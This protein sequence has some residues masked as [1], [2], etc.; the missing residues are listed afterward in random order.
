MRKLLFVS[1]GILSFAAISKAQGDFVTGILTTTAASCTLGAN[2]NHVA[3][4]SVGF[5]G[6]V[7]TLSAGGFTGAVTFYATG[8]GGTVWTPLAVTPSGGGTAV[9]TA[10]ATGAWQANVSA[11]THVCILLTTDTAGSI[12]AKI[13]LSPISARAGGGGGG[14]GMIYPGAGIAVSTGSAWGTSITGDPNAIAWLTTPTAVNLGTAL[15]SQPANTVFAAPSGAAGNPTFRPLVAADLPATTTSLSSITSA[16]TIPAALASGANDI[17]WNWTNTTGGSSFTFGETNPSTGGTIT[18]AVN[19][20]AILQALT[21]AGSTATPLSVTQGALTGT[22]APPAMQLSTTWNASGT[23][24]NGI[25]LS[26]TNTA[27]A[28]GSEAFNIMNNG[29]SVFSVTPGGL[30]TANIFVST[31]NGGFKTSAGTVPSFVSTS[32]TG[33]VIIAGGVGGSSTNGTQLGSVVL[34]GADNIANGA[35]SSGGAALLQGGFTQNVAGTGN[36]GTVE[37][38]AGFINGTVAN[39]NDIVCATTGQSTV[40]DCGTAPQVNVIGV[41]LGSSN[42]VGVVVQGL[43]PVRLSAPLTAI[44]DTV[45]L[46]TTTAGTGTDSGGQGMCAT[47]GATVGVIVNSTG[48][49]QV[50]SSGYAGN[51]AP[52]T[53]TLSTTLPL[54]LLHIR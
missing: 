30:T 54:V 7:F 39:A 12:A 32:T 6:A 25:L 4:S 11:Y 53:V 29:P 44:G 46:S 37:M 3:I 42:P 2:S 14:G 19:N 26:L 17:T 10:S 28:A 22:I 41:S 24:F 13:H 50:S 27:S 52:Q 45:C 34:K 33:N 49:V 9:T 35:N 21:A 31:A 48:T 36:F 18:S 38:S 5:G 20:Q 47:A 8:D 1:I 51:G 16:T 43:V 15:G 23:V 40:T